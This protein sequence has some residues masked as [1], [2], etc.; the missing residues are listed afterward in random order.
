MILTHWTQTQSCT[1]QL[2][3]KNQ[4]H[5]IKLSLWHTFINVSRKDFIL[6]ED[7]TILVIINLEIKA[8]KNYMLKT[9]RI[10]KHK[11]TQEKHEIVNYTIIKSYNDT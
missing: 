9:T 8:D 5:S 4:E 10:E 3:I 2:N 11:I 1:A 6:K 7:N